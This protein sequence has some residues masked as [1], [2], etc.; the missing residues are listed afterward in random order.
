MFI[1]WNISTEWKKYNS[2]EALQLIPAWV[3][4][5]SFW[6]LKITSACQI[7]KQP[8][9]ACISIQSQNTTDT[10]LIQCLPFILY[11]NSQVWLNLWLYKSVVWGHTDCK[12]IVLQ[13][14]PPGLQKNVKFK[15]VGELNLSKT[16]ITAQVQKMHFPSFP[17]SRSH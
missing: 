17:G 1:L 10:E 15:C 14:P 6:Y 9:L 11:S 5:S 13:H 16:I 8:V 4:G 12:Q 7:L 2:Q 3:G